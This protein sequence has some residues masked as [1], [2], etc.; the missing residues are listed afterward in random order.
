VQFLALTGRETGS[1]KQTASKSCALSLVRQLFHLG[2]IEAYS[3]TLKTTKE[4]DQ[5][6]PYEVAISPELFD[7]L[8]DTLEALQLKPIA[9]VSITNPKRYLKRLRGP[10]SYS[11]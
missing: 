11:R 8:N 10:C 5:V 3:G 4:G 6:K 1:N 2:V 9:V 7:Q